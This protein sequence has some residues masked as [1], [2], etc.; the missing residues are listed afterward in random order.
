MEGLN[1]LNRPH[2]M[3]DLET[4]SQHQNATIVSIGAVKFTF[5]EGLGE[6]FLINVS[7]KSC[8]EKGLHVS[9]STVEWWQQQ[10]KEVRDAWLINPQPLEH[11][12]KELNRFVGTE[13]NMFVWAHG[14]VFDMG[15]LTSAFHACTIEKSWKYWQENDSRT[16]FNLLGVR[17]D[18]IRKEEGGYHTA[19]GDAKSQA[20]TL[21]GLFS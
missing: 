4:L 11:A 16:I 18:K 1:I 10:P 20:K 12:L 15:I 2:V 3:I 17:N 21:I 9:K 14:S 8:M 19:L 6:E 5:E 13:K 7:A